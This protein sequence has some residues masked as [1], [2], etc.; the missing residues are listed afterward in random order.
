ECCEIT[1]VPVSIYPFIGNGEKRAFEDD[2][3]KEWEGVYC[4]SSLDDSGRMAFSM[5]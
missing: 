3:A 2:M 5:V 1:R 4:P